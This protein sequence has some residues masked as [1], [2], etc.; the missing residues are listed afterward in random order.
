M[1][2]LFA[3]DF[4]GIG[5][6]PLVEHAAVDAAEVG[7]VGEVFF[8]V[9]YELGGFA[10]EASVDLAAHDEEWGGGA[11][12]GATTAVFGG[13]SAK[14]GEGHGQDLVVFTVGGE[15]FLKGAHASGELAQ[16]T[17]MIV[18]LI[19]V[20]IVAALRDEIDA[21][22]QIGVDE[23]GHAL[24][25]LGQIC[26]WVVG[27]RL[28]FTDN[29]FNASLRDEGV[30]HGVLE[31]AGIALDVVGLEQFFVGEIG[32]VLPTIEAASVFHT[33]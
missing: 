7:R 2:E 5:F 10:E 28:V 22:L 13:A 19:G 21:S 4:A 20:G 14:L 12:V 8:N 27:L 26:A 6:E 11:V 23:G 1:L 17:L 18:E 31:V 3:E 9:S 33:E 25:R 30:H 24:E 16:E 29:F 32:G 15:V